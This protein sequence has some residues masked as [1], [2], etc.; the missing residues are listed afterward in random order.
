[1]IINVP[2]QAP[3]GSIQFTAVMN[4]QQVQALLQ[5]GMNMA[6]AMGIASTFT[7]QPDD[8]QMPL[9]FND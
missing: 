1:M 3:D 9:E 7:T 5:F 2:V 4:E 8:N 6:F